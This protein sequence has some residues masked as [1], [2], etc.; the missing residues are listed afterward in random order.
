MPLSSQELLQKW[1]AY[2]REDIIVACLDQARTF[3]SAEKG[4]GRKWRKKKI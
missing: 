4:G 2:I 3:S 1:I